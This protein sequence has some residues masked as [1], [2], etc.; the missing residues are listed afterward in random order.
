MYVS[1]EEINN[2]IFKRCKTKNI[3]LKKMEHHFFSLEIKY[4]YNDITNNIIYFSLQDNKIYFQVNKYE[5]LL[6]YIFLKI[7]SVLIDYNTYVYVYDSLQNYMHFFTM[8]SIILNNNATPIYSILQSENKPYFDYLIENNIIL[9]KNI[10]DGEDNIHI[11]TFKPN[12]VS[13]TIKP[14]N[15]YF[16]DDK[17]D[18]HLLKIYDKAIINSYLTTNKSVNVFFKTENVN[19]DYSINE[20]IKG[21]KCQSKRKKVKLSTTQKHKPLLFEIKRKSLNSITRK[22]RIS[23]RRSLRTLRVPLGAHREIFKIPE[24]NNQNI[25]VGLLLITVH[26]GIIIEETPDSQLHLPI[27]TIPVGHTKLYYKTI[28]L[29]GYYNYFI[30][31]PQDVRRSLNSED[32]DYDYVG[33]S[34]L[35]E[36]ESGNSLVGSTTK[37]NHDIT[38]GHYRNVFEKCFKTNPLQFNKIFYSCGN[39]I[40]NKFLRGIKTPNVR[41]QDNKIIDFSKLNKTTGPGP[42]HT[43]LDKTLETG[44]DLKENTKITFI[45]FNNSSKNFEKYNLSNFSQS[46]VSLIRN[47][48]GKDMKQMRQLYE[49]KKG[50][51]KLSSLIE[52][53]L[54]Y[55]KG[56]DSLYV[57][58][59]SCSSYDTAV[60]TRRLNE[61]D[62]LID[63]LPE[64][65]GR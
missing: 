14:T 61:I 48:F 12:T 46:N 28:T 44:S 43:I 34:L 6:F 2:L 56:L 51:I 17:D 45:V 39:K 41:P 19:L 47:I 62:T 49:L 27:V 42:V 63:T 16:I 10:D 35:S 58:D 54:T 25:N 57:Y 50:R 31:K 37:N 53:V 36:V 65:I 13:I 22:K 20:L 29:P 7:T 1:L 33:D 5:P 24:F 32:N 23:N 11:T 38:L 60:E 55:T 64:Y 9:K 26:G 3:F 8:I 18:L 30:T 15:K 21:M 4:R 59:T 52:L 40:I